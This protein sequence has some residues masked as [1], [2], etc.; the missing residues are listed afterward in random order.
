MDIRPDVTIQA[1]RVAMFHRSHLKT[2]TA[3]MAVTAM[4]RRPQ[5]MD[6][7]NKILPLRMVHTG[8]GNTDKP[9]RQVAM[10]SQRL[11]VVT[12]SQPHRLAMG[13]QRLQVAMGNHMASTVKRL[14]RVIHWRRATHNHVRRL[15]RYLSGR[16]TRV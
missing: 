16:A 5:A 11:Q 13:N 2:R 10:A 9:L 8:R 6:R 12:A 14:R 15:P 7:L 1:R 4:P 3:D